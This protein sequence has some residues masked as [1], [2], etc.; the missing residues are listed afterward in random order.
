MFRPITIGL[1]TSLLLLVFAGTA[2]A[3]DVYVKT[4]YAKLRAGTTSRDATVAKLKHG[5]K[6]TVLETKSGFLRVKA[7]D[8]KEGWIAKSWTT[9]KLRSRSKF[10]EGLGA[11]ARGGGNNDV[12]F[13]AGARGLSSQA[14]SFAGDSPD[15]KAVVVSIEKLEK[16]E[17]TVD[18]LDKFLQD[19]QLGDYRQE[20]IK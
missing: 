13:T 16:I 3:D 10:L 5:A 7:S 2:V 18:E 14:A 1:I 6:L 15:L 9:P 4:R 20:A 12:S 17:V 19:G 8:G 11:A